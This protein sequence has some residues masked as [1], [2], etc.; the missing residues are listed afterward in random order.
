MGELSKPQVLTEGENPRHLQ[1]AE[2]NGFSVPPR[3]PLM[4]KLS[5][6]QILTEG[7]ITY[8]RAVPTSSYCRAGRLC[9]HPVAAALVRGDRTV[10]SPRIDVFAAI[11]LSCKNYVSTAIYELLSLSRL[12]RQLPLAV[13]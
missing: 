1:C 9:R 5:K 12:R 10:W 8:L 11:D 4:R 7:E 3:L 6:S 2:H 13:A